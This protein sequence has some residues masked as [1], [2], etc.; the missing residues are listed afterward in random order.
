MGTRPQTSGEE[1]VGRVWDRDG[2]MS[3]LSISLSPH[4][5]RTTAHPIATYSGRNVGFICAEWKKT[6]AVFVDLL[7][8]EERCRVK[9]TATSDF[10]LEKERDT[11]MYSYRKMVHTK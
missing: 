5:L 4:L 2:L 3:L 10:M 9:D 7:E 6:E 1:L 11:S 8:F